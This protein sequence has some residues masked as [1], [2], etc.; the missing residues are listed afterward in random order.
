MLS[1]PMLSYRIKGSGAELTE[2][3]QNETSLKM[4]VGRAHEINQFGW[5]QKIEFSI[6]SLL[7]KV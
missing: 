6:L 1:T 7:E 4:L 2:S 3:C 5:K